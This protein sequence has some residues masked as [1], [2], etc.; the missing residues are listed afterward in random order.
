[1]SVA[2]V[3]A[4]WSLIVVAVCVS[5]PLLFDVTLSILAAL[6]LPQ[7][8]TAAISFRLGAWADRYQF[9]LLVIDYF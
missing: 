2:G 4:V 8:R 5:L 7:V 9:I 1:M 3:I 6:G